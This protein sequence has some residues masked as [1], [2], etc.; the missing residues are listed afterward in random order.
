MKSFYNYT[1]DDLQKKL[2]DDGFSKFH[3]KQLFDWVYR[4]QVLDQSRWTN[5]SKKLKEYLFSEFDFMGCYL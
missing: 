3:A 5:V 2:V 4:K 1:L